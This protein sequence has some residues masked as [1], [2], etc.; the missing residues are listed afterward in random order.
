MMKKL[1]FFT[2][3]IT[4]SSVINVINATNYTGYC[5]AQCACFKFSPEVN[6]TIHPAT[7]V[8]VT[9]EQPDARFTGYKSLPDKLPDETYALDL[10][11]N[12]ITHLT[13]TDTFPT[14]R[15]LKLS[16]NTLQQVDKDAFDNLYN[17][18]TLFLSYNTLST[19]HSSTFAALNNLTHLD[20]S[21]NRLSSLP[22]DIFHNNLNLL[23]LIMSSNPLLNILPEWFSSLHN[24]QKL[25]LSKTQLYS[26]RPETFHTLHM[27]HSL[28]LSGNLF[29]DVPTEALTPVGSTLQVLKL[30]ENRLNKLD[31]NSF[32][33]LTSLL[34]LQI[35]S[36]EL[37]MTIGR[38]T[39]SHLT[40]LRNL[41]VAENRA[42]SFIHPSAL[43]RMQGERQPATLRTLSLRGNH[44]SNLTLDNLGEL[45]ALD[46]LD[47]RS[48]PWHCDCHAQWIHDCSSV[49]GDPRCASPLQYKT[50][51]IPSMSRS[52]FVCSTPDARSSASSSHSIDGSS[53][54]DAVND[55]KVAKVLVILMACTLLLVLG[56][57]IVL[58][59]KRSDLIKSN[60]RRGNG[61][62]Y[63]VKAQS[64]PTG[65]LNDVPTG[66]LI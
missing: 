33:H 39:F 41:T 46:K 56:I 5:P 18:Q 28:D 63:Y 66:S 3:L 16:T 60:V 40:N 36:N 12:Q 37:L 32:T 22:R 48:N 21:N 13:L 29:S 14:L 58:V 8:W 19:L 53:S 1:I 24:L 51:A 25:D 50:L 45:C 23:E 44:L 26:I 17:L 20:V 54:H 4:V 27:L 65:Y 9:C 2:V 59:L 61:S 6:L 49:E 7:H 38:R 52:E 31:E 47:L 15:Y 10:S 62:I 30:N 35:C 55:V 42:L 57:S 11:L 34:E 43:K 64:T